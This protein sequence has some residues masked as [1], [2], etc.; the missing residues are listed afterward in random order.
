MHSN[1]TIDILLVDATKIEIERPK[2]QKQY[3]KHTLKVWLVVEAK[4]LNVMRVCIDKGRCHDFILFK[5]SRLD[6]CHDTKLIADSG[7]QG[8]VRYHKNS[9][10]PIKSSKKHKLSHGEKQYNHSISKKRIYIEHVNRYL[11]RFRIISSCYKN[12]RRR[13]SLRIS[14]LCDIYNLQH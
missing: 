3:Y 8:I 1:N 11:K 7:Y 13:F 9:Q 14:L 2:K 6:I 10:I 12:K 5:N 4:K